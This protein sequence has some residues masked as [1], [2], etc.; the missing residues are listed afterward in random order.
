MV[1]DL[2]V[3]ITMYVVPRMYFVNISSDSEANASES[4]EN[5]EEM[6]DDGWIIN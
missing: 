6:F 3:H 5:I 2:N 4:L 1:K